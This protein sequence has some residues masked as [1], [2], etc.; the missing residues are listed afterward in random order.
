[1][2]QTPVISYTGTPFT[3]TKDVA[4]S[5]ITPTNTGGTATSWSISPNLPTGLT[6]DTSTGEIIGTPS[7]LQITPITYTITATNTGGTD[8]TTISLSILDSMPSISYTQND[9]TLT[10][11]TATSTVS[12]TNSGGAVTS[13]S[14]SPAFSNG[15]NFDT[16]TGEITG[17]PNLI[18]TRTQFTITATNSGG[19]STAYVNITVNDIAPSISYPVS[20]LFTKGQTISLIYATN[21]GGTA[22][23]WEVSDL[24]SGLSIDSSAGYIWGTPQ[25]V[26]PTTTYT[27][28]ANN[29]GGSSST[30][31]TITVNDLPAGS[32]AYNPTDM[33]LTLNQAMTPNTV[34][35]GGGAVTSLSLIHI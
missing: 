11:G 16:S 31:I 23:S 18:Q 1:M 33:V 19:S 28:W 35:P 32:F 10:K 24:P 22:T 17:T 29:S 9:L 6:F 14:I 3:L 25:T 4:I 7:I 34:S 26:T 12:P 20:Y 5:T 8:T 2:D 27:V 13:W 30:S 15:L 21:T